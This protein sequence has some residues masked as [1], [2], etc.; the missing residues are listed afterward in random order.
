MKKILLL[1]ILFI[2]SIASI[3]AQTRWTWDQYGLSFEA[4]S[5]MKVTEN[6]EIKFSAEM[7]GMAVSMEVMDYEGL[8]PDNG[9]G[10]RRSCCKYGHVRKQ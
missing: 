4:P 8:T 7:D 10:I 2:A 1:S 9:R 6:D 3:N 5:S